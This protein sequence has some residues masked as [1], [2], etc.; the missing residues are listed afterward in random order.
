MAAAI[1]IIGGVV[2]AIGAM[3]QGQAQADAANYQAQVARNNEIIALQQSNLAKQDGAIKAQQQDM[4]SAQTL[5]TQRAVL[6]AS[7]VDIESGS[8]REVVASQSELARLDALTIQSNA[9]RK[10]WGFDIEATNQK[11]QAGLYR[12]QASHAKEAGMLNAFSSL[13]GGFGKVAGK[14][15][16]GGGG[17]GE[18]L[19]S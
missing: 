17:G 5:G 16:G 6:G 8:A 14:W 13:L 2:S 4:K 18:S 10:A 1:G 3:K 19:I 12:M 11:A 15:G 9:E 7:G